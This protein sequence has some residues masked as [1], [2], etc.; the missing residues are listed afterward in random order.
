MLH[1]HVGVFGRESVQICARLL[2][3]EVCEPQEFRSPQ[4]G[5]FAE[6]GACTLRKKSSASLPFV[7]AAPP[8]LPTE[9]RL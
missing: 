5:A 1:P 2:N 6:T 3:S 8:R 4:C 9:E 7:F